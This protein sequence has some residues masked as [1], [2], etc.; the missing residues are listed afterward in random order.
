MR[1][2]R[3]RIVFPPPL[4]PR[5]PPR[6]RC[7]TASNALFELHT[8][9]YRPSPYNA[10]IHYTT[11]WRAPADTRNTKEYVFSN[12]P[13]I[14]FKCVFRLFFNRSKNKYWDFSIAIKKKKKYIKFSI[15]GFT[16]PFIFLTIRNRFYRYI[17]FIY[18][19]YYRRFVF[20][21]LTRRQKYDLRKIKIQTNKPYNNMWFQQ[22][23]TI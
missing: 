18:I 10:Y 5:L 14:L 8:F 1:T 6:R 12:R 3:R 22:L 2:A 15:F 16:V 4:P 21:L 13:R 20:F 11:H 17:M 9:N 19:I 7:A 23:K